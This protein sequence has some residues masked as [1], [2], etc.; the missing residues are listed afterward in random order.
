VKAIILAGGRGTRLAPYTTILPK[1]LMP[2]GEKPVLELLIERIRES[3]INEII[4]AVGY[5]AELI[6]SYFGDGSKYGVK[7][8]YQK[9]EKPLGTAGPIAGIKDLNESFLVV[10]G[11]IL[12][13]LDFKALLAFHKSK[14]ALVTIA[15]HKR[16][17]KIDYGLIELND[18]DRIVSYTEKPVMDHLVSMG[19]Y[20]F[21]PSILHFMQENTKQDI[22]DLIKEVIAK[23]GIVCGYVSEDYWLDI[24]RPSDYEQALKDMDN[25]KAK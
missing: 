19:I 4:L 3:G 1:P 16:Q 21:E 6:M 17:T 25:F 9:E 13:T 20:V 2:L 12:T 14:K 8:F 7:L 5:L 24:G 11:D 22:P 18:D 10:N 23:N 15:L